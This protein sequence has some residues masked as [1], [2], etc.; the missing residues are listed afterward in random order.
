MDSCT[1]DHPRPFPVSRYVY[2]DD[3][4]FYY[5]YGN[6]P[7]DDYLENA[8]GITEP[9]ILLLGCGDLRSCLYTLW[10][11]FDSHVH[12]NRF[13]GVHFVLNDNS[14]AILARDVLFLYLCLKTP[15]EKEEVKEWLCAVWAIWFCHELL[16]KHEAVLNEALSSL[17]K[18]A[19]SAK[20]WSSSSNPL[21]S[22]VKFTCSQVLSEISQVWKMW[23]GKDIQGINSVADMNSSRKSEQSTRCP[24]ASHFVNLAV[25]S[26]SSNM[27]KDIQ[28][29]M[30]TEVSSY[31]ESGSVFVEEV[32]NRP[33]IVSR[34]LVNFTLYERRDGQYTLHYASVPFMCFFHSFHYSENAIKTPQ[35]YL[36]IS[37]SYFETRPFLAN[38]MQQFGLWI[39]TCARALTQENGP[40]VSFTVH[41][42]D[43][44]EFCQILQT[45]LHIENLEVANKFDLIYTSNLIDHLAPPN[46]ILSA[47]PLLKPPGYLFTVT[48]TYKTVGSSAE[49]YIHACFGFESKLLPILFGIRCVNHEGSNY[50]STIA[51]QPLSIS[52]GLVAQWPKLLIWEKMNMQPQ[53]LT[54][55][56]CMSVITYALCNSVCLCATALLVCMKGCATKNNLCLETAIKILQTY[57]LTLD[58]DVSSYQFWSPLCDQLILQEQTIKPF[59]YALQTQCILHNLHLHLTVN[60]ETCPICKGVPLSEY[61]H[62]CSLKVSL[63]LL[64]S[65]R[66]PCFMTFVHTTKITTP[67]NL[68]MLL[69]TDTDVHIFDCLT[70]CREANSITLTFY[71]PQSFTKKGYTVTLVSYGIAKVLFTDMN[72]PHVVSHMKLDDCCTPSIVTH[73]FQKT[74]SATPAVASQLGCVESHSGD[75]DNFKTL[76]QLSHATLSNLEAGTTVSVEQISSS[77]IEIFC[78]TL[79]HKI[80]YP[81]PIEYNKLQIKVSRKKQKIT[82]LA[83]R[84]AHNFVEENALF[85]VNPENKLSLPPIDVSP[86]VYDL[87]CGLQFTH[88][89]QEI[90]NSCKVN[91]K[92]PPRICLKQTIT[93]LFQCRDKFFFHITVPD[94]FCLY[95]GLIIIQSYLFDVQH[96]TPAI[97]L[98]FCFL[99]E[100]FTD[101]LMN[102]WNIVSSSKSRDIPVT[103]DEYELLTKVL[104]YFSKRTVGNFN[105][106]KGE[107]QFKVLAEQCID[108]YFTRAVVYPLYSD[109]DTYTMG[110]DFTKPPHE[111]VSSFNT[112]TSSTETIKSLTEHCSQCGLKSGDLKKC[113]KCSK[114]QYCGRECQSKHWKEHKPNC[115]KT[116][117][118]TS[119]MSPSTPITHSASGSKKIAKCSQC[120]TQSEDLKKCTGCGEVQYCNRQC[121]EKNWLD[122]KP[123]CYKPRDSTPDRGVIS[124]SKNSSPTLKTSSVVGAAP[125]DTC[126]QCGAQS[127]DLRKCTKCGKVQYCDKECQKKNWKEHKPMCQS[128]VMEATVSVHKCDRR[129]KPLKSSE[130]SELGKSYLY[131]YIVNTGITVS[132]HNYYYMQVQ[133]LLLL[134][135]FLDIFIMVNGCIIMV[136]VTLHRTIFLRMHLK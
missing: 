33:V 14:A 71:C 111:Q 105:D 42:S 21:H 3:Y 92:M 39:Q 23:H 117:E 2:Y 133:V 128:A 66:T 89:E 11:N 35:Q 68:L 101:K 69:A 94:S 130:K 116:H 36:L 64:D 20:S 75:G 136:M 44:I 38:S 6:T 57:A 59:L 126:T 55:L 96:M 125:N 127:A 16:P 1:A 114:V 119:V 31:L 58:S 135:Q 95:R 18:F 60:E 107:G 34:T 134:F 52:A 50:S 7:P 19:T 110:F 24:V 25:G 124:G 84:K 15:K 62:S 76:V 73:S 132:I 83:T 100:S 79:E 131:C 61:V 78:G 103:E 115:H 93:F 10:K 122:H 74:S 86:E 51:V 4:R 45:P 13:N 99:K 102:A 28:S 81:H 46:L 123:N 129:E 85:H 112:S 43:A 106:S 109:P 88:Q 49:E 97:D 37:N 32:M 17:I 120:G 40:K 29:R 67:E 27:P 113:S 47:L 56:D 87:A 63:P 5:G 65:G 53:K 26:R 48:Q 77:D 121:Q 30:K 8:S 82:I 104:N 118:L 91:V 72:V 70:G 22:L 90:V 108:R 9:S 12:S 98:A 41:C 80:C 54:S